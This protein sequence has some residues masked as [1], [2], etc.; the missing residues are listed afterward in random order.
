MRKHKIL[1]ISL[2]VRDKAIS[3]KFLTPGVFKNYIATFPKIFKNSGHFEFF[4]FSL[5]MRKHK[6][7]YI[8]LTVRDRAISSKF[9]TPRVFKNK[10]SDMVNYLPPI[11][12]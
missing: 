9:W 10:T 12:L 7:A 2:T 6:N 5:K 4:E 11:E 8:F 3:S 1:T